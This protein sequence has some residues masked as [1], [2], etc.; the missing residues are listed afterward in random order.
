MIMYLYQ[1]EKQSIELSMK[2]VGVKLHVSG[3]KGSLRAYT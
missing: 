1:M 3:L 2:H